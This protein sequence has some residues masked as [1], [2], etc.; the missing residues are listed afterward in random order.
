MATKNINA[1]IQ[2]KI[3]TYS[4]W[5][6]ASNFR[7][8]YGELIIFIPDDE[9]DTRPIQMKIGNKKEDLLADL[10]FITNIVEDMIIE[11]SNNPISSGAIYDVLYSEY[12][13]LNA[14]TVDGLHL[15]VSSTVPIEGE[16]D[17][18]T[19]IFVI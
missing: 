7:P 10:P 8:L 18:N 6:L 9:T 5:N 12:S 1:R 2:H 3:D 15:K 13:D 4:H 19:I 11:G 14:Q 17:E 16:E